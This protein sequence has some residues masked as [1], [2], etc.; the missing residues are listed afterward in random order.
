MV[1]IENMLNTDLFLYLIAFLFFTSG[2]LPKKILS[3]LSTVSDINLGFD[4]HD[5]EETN[6]VGG[7]PTSLGTI[8]KLNTAGQYPSQRTAKQANS[9]QSN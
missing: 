7:D 9:K 5:K 3:S 2:P 4:S 8:L 1:A 6:R